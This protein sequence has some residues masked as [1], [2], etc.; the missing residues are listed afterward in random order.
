MED[1]VVRGADFPCIEY[2]AEI[3]TEFQKCV[4]KVLLYKAQRLHQP[5]GSVDL[6]VK[7]EGGKHVFASKAY[8]TGELK[9]V[10]FSKYVSIAVEGKEKQVL[11]T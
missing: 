3:V 5:K 4:V 9:L 6:K 10:P 7:G 2:D 8:A 11:W 1:I